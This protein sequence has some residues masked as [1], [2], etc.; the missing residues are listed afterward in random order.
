MV[1]NLFPLLVGLIYLAVYLSGASLFSIKLTRTPE[2][3]QFVLFLLALSATTTVLAWRREYTY[4]HHEAPLRPAPYTVQEVVSNMLPL[5]VGVTYLAAYLSEL[6]LFSIKLTRMPPYD[7]F[8]LFFLALS[9]I[10]TV[11]AWRRE[12]TLTQNEIEHQ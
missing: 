4:A 12:Y 11:L 3:D 6:S 2:F 9:A 5:L 10:T 1:R 7:Q 8:A